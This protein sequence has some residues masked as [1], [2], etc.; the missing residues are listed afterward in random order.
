MSPNKQA[1][2]WDLEVDSFWRLSL[3]TNQYYALGIMK[4]IMFIDPKT[5]TIIIRLGD[6]SDFGN[7]LTLTYKI[8]RV[9]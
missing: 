8:N 4:Q 7:Y 1:K 2:Y 5:R 3:Y 9:L 6:G